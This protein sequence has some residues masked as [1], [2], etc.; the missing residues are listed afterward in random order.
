MCLSHLL[1]GIQTGT[2]KQAEITRVDGQILVDQPTHQSV[3]Q[4]RSKPLKPRLSTA[5]LALAIYHIVAFAVA[6][7]HLVDDV[8]GILH[9]RV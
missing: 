7:D 4:P 5:G 8:E 9:I 3:E 1:Q 2:G 6:L